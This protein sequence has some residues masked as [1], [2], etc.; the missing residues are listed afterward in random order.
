MSQ[1]RAVHVAVH[2][3]GPSEVY[4]KNN[5]RGTTKT[6]SSRSESRTAIETSR[7]LVTI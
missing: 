2:G 4:K 5:I 6:P 1:A 3:A 7:S